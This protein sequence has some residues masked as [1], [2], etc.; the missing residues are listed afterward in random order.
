MSAPVAVER[1]DTVLQGARKQGICRIRQ[2]TVLV[3]DTRTV[4]YPSTAAPHR[5][6][7]VTHC[8]HAKVV[9]P[10][11]PR[12]H[13][14]AERVQTTRAVGARVSGG[15]AVLVPSGSR[16]VPITVSSLTNCGSLIPP[17]IAFVEG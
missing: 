10:I 13:E 9:G 7:L 16:A 2:L 11:E 4:K 5:L 17:G 15:V 3:S 8:R 6:Q 14:L 12:A 1:G